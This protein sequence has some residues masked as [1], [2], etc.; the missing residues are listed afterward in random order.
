VKVVEILE[1]YS[2]EALDRLASDK[3][4]EISNLRLPR[5]VLIHEIATAL[6]SLSYV[7]AALAP[8]RP[9]TYAFVK[10]LLDVPDHTLD[11]QGFREKVLGDTDSLTERVSSGKILSASKNY[12]LYLALLK[13]AYEND[14]V[15]DRS[16]A[17]LLTSLRSQLGIWT[18]EH[19]LLEHHA[20]VRPFWEGAQI[21][22]RARN[23]LLTTG[24]VLMVEDR[25]IIAA[26]VCRAIRQVWEIDLEDD[27]YQRLLNQLT[28]QQIRAILEAAAL[29]L[30]GHK[31]ER[32]ERVIR[33]LVPPAEALDVL[34]IN[35]LKDL[36]RAVGHPVSAA[37]SDL[38][39]SLVEYFDQDGDLLAQEEEAVQPTPP[40]EPET[41][42]LS[43]RGFRLLFDQLTIDQL[44]DVLSSAQLKRSGSKS[45]KIDRLSECPWSETTLLGH[46]RR[47]DLADLCRSL[48]VQVSG[49]KSELI[50]RLVEWAARGA[51]ALPIPSIPF[52]RASVEYQF[53]SEPAEVLP[54]VQKEVTIPTSHMKDIGSD[55]PVLS[56]DEKIVISLLKD[57]RSL[58][59]KE[60]ERS[61]S[62]HRLGWFLTKAHMADL[63]ARLRLEGQCPVRVRSVGAV[64]IY[65]WVDK[66]PA[67]DGQMTKQAARDLVD[68]LRQGVVPEKHLEQL[69]V[70]QE[71]VRRHLV[72]L[73]DHV[74]TGK[75]EF[76]FV[77]G[78]YGSG[79]TFLCSWLREMAYQAEFA[80]STVRIG[81][82][83]PLSDLPVFFSGIVNGLRTPEKRHASA[84]ADILESWLLGVHRRTCELEGIDPMDQG[85]QPK[86]ASVVGDRIEDELAR[87]DGVE[88][89]F[90]PAMGAFYQARLEGDQERAAAA[91]A[92]LR[93]S[94]SVPAAALKSIGVRG[95]LETDQVFPRL[96]ALLEVIRG[97]RL[98][99]LLL[100]VDELEL[101]RRMPHARQREQAYETLRLLIDEV[102]ENALPG[103]LLV[104][105]GT[106]S[107]FDDQRYGMGSYEALANRVSP[108]TTIEGLTSMRQPVI[109]LEPLDRSMLL[110]VTRRARQ[111]HGVAYGWDSKSRVPDST[112]EYLVDTWTTFGDG[113]VD[114]LPRP[115]LRQLVN[116]LDLCEENPHVS[117]EDC[118]QSSAAKV[119][120][121]EALAG[122]LES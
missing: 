62:R 25:Y 19:L 24:L 47:S 26:E 77:R 32:V 101:I 2:D 112:L 21:F 43:E 40:P 111:I 53:A 106:D 84:L 30:S 52:D 64:N 50:E 116:V 119:D 110:E 118:L 46:A 75:S 3:I 76:K 100:L 11:V 99:G 55:Y 115:T 22:E 1:G 23:H 5:S 60:V 42:T 94:R 48:G 86:L 35:E 15:I 95:H 85:S 96:S 57:A 6:S 92:W 56:Q 9:A 80:V 58:T 54:E 91:I 90:G 67:S 45:A 88:P 69:C 65:E 27:T 36:C 105:T 72:E 104:F 74:K 7:G 68:A 114:R 122:F 71:A 28:G 70:G 83:Q 59:E 102:G 103:C 61:A 51:I 113:N 108:P 81:P 34:S 38:I 78:P 73:L 20:D 29:P 120:D 33:G 17:L 41:R 4:E 66:D 13:T 8:T 10:L 14:G 107:L 109:R 93:G 12:S 97:G 18:R 117:A 63:M 44:Y 121:A 82:D 31:E 98:Q 79:K 37:K 89:G 39:E 87:L 49:V 16:E